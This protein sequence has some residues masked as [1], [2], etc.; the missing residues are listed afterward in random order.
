MLKGLYRAKMMFNEYEVNRDVFRK[1][2][3]LRAGRVPSPIP[4]QL[5]NVA[6]I[7]KLNANHTQNEVYF[8]IHN[9]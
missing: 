4:C 7:D 1:R 5:L 8:Q 6:V 3:R 9:R 2:M